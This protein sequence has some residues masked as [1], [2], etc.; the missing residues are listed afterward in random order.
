MCG[1]FCYLEKNDRSKIDLLERS[2]ENVNCLKN[3]GP[4]SSKKIYYEYKIYNLFL[5]HSRLAIQDVSM[6]IF[7]PTLIKVQ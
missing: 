5:Y 2:L 7:N 3:R 6:N 4:D 1:F